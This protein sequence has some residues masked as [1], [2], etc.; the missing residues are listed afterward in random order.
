MSKSIE[1]KM[2]DIYSYDPEKLGLRLDE[3]V[4]VLKEFRNKLPKSLSNKDNDTHVISHL[5]AILNII[6]YLEIPTYIN[7]DPGAEA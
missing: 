2:I 7:D 6:D 1:K 4:S 3:T 5:Q